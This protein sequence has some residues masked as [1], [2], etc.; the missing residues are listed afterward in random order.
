VK[1]TCVDNIQGIPELSREYPSE[2]PG[3]S[4]CSLLSRLSDAPME[5]EGVESCLVW[6][7]W[8]L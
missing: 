6:I 7:L 1:K 5:L 4:F 8:V 2:I 3:K